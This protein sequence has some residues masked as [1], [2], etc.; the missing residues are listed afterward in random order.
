SRLE[1]IGSIAATHAEWYFDA[2][3]KGGL[4][5]PTFVRTAIAGFLV[6]MP[7]TLLSMGTSPPSSTPSANA[8]EFDAAAE[9][10]KG[11]D[12]LQAS[13]FREAKSSFARV[14]GVAP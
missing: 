4:M 3:R 1:P 11:I 12:A 13:K 10:R 5:H 7:T 8:T 9:Y 2:R 6:A 14:L